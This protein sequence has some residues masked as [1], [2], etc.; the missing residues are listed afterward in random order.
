MRLLLALSF[1]SLGLVACG[2][3]NNASMDAQAVASRIQKVGSV[4]LQSA[5]GGELRSGEQ[6]YQA[7]CGAC[8]SSGALGAPKLG[9]NA[10]WGARIG[11]GYDALLVS[12]LK[13]KGNMAAQGGGAFSDLE[14]GR[15]VVYMANKSGGNLAEP[16]K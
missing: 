9:D 13:G 7:Q 14:I 5:G 8:H 12:A 2:N 6:V 10:A 11:K 3:A 1:A 15:A 16:K 4:Q